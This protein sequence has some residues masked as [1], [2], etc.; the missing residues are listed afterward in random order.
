MKI[1]NIIY[2][3][4]ALLAALS[5]GK[6]PGTADNTGGQTPPDEMIID[7]K[8]TGDIAAEHL[9]IDNERKKVVVDFPEGTVPSAVE[10]TFIL[11]EGVTVKDAEGNV[12]I[13]DLRKPCAV[14]LDYAG[15]DY[16]YLV[17]SNYDGGEDVQEMKEGPVSDMVL[18]YYGGSH[19]VGK[20]DWTDEQ[21]GSN[22]IYKDK[23]GNSHWLFD[24]FLF[25]E[26]SDGGGHYFESGF[27]NPNDP[28]PDERGANKED[29]TKILDKYF[30]KDGP[31]ARLDNEISKAIQTLGLPVYKR[32][33]VI[34]IPVPFYNQKNWGSLNGKTMDFSQMAHRVDASKWYVDEVIDRYHSLNLRYLSLHG[35]YYVAE[36]LTNNRDYVPAVAEYINSRN[37]KFY[38]IPYWG[39]DGMGDWK[40]MKFNEA[41]LQPNYAFPAEKPDYASYFR[42]IMNFASSKGMNLEMEF[43]EYALYNNRFND[44]RADRVRDY[45]KAFNEYKV[46]EN[47]KIAYY[48]SDCMIHALKTSSYAQDNDLYYELCEM[49]SGRQQKRGEK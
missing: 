37:L 19:R 2:A 9:V 43:D 1:R 38:W 11:E 40:S 18:M 6:E 28:R 14:V 5:C 23:N 20:S 44:Y 26:I 48:Q 24:S 36:Q 47:K 30:A 45:I 39:A 3:F 41:F 12:C 15:Q 7:I 29:W 46:T 22:V 10:M 4:T 49:I 8:F 33:L 35:I 21:L 31:I 13:L 16:R 25:L 42:S 34:F 27:D 32:N 17:I